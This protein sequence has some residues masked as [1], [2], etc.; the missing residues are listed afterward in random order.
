MDKK[1]SLVLDEEVLK[2]IDDK[3][4]ESLRSRS[5]YIEFILRESL[6]EEK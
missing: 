2:K 6:K 4:K 1:I 5:K 3:A